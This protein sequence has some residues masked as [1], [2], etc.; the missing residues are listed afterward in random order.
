MGEVR[1]NDEQ[2]RWRV[3]SQIFSDAAARDFAYAAPPM[4]RDDDQVGVLL[5]RNA[6]KLR[7]WI[8]V[9]IDDRAHREL[10]SAQLGAKRVEIVAC[11]ALVL[12]GQLH[13]E[14]R[15]LTSGPDGFSL[16]HHV[17]EDQLGTVSTGDPQRNRKDAFGDR[18]DVS[19]SR[20]DVSRPSEG[21][22]PRPEGCF[23]PSEGRFVSSEAIFHATE[24]RVAWR[25]DVFSP[26]KEPS[27]GRKDV[28][29]A[30]ES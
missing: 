14:F 10:L 17:R 3:R 21:R 19:A 18:K 29:F 4:R 27:P 28:L 9:G 26:R 12:R 30:R 20:K 25:K 23:C 13:T 8:A 2:R 7:A 11:A 24:G 6:A 15:R 5:D 22:F 1:P 16:G